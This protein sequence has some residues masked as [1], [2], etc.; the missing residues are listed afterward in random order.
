[1]NLETTLERTTPSSAQWVAWTQQ[2]PALADLAYQDMRGQLR[3]A[4]AARKD[5]LLGAVVCLV[6]HDPGA[7]GVLAACMLPAL[8]HR[9]A[10]HAPSLHR[11]DALAVVVAGLYEAAIRYDVELHP[12]YVAEKLLALPTRRL[13]RA[14]AVDRRWNVRARHAADG[15]SHAAGPEL[16]L[17]GLMAAAVNAGVLA[18]HEARLILAT[19]VDGRTV[20]EVA[21]ELGLSYEAARKRRRRAE[22]RWAAW[23]LQDMGDGGGPGTGEGAA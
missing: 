19:R 16:S 12:R 3:T 20:P 4:G 15:V 1:M 13:R 11:Q 10:L 18:E 2:E 23:W 5:E 6:Q 7:F 17:R 8:R 22:A 21:D 14:V 9:V